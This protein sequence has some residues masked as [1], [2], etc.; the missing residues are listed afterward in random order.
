MAQNKYSRTNFTEEVIVDG[1]IEQDLADNNWDLFE[2]KR[3]MTFFTLGR[4]YIG[5]PDLLSLKLYGKMD[6]WWLLAKAND[7]D[8]FW[9]DIKVGDVI[10]V[11]DVR[12]FEDFY[13][14]VRK[15]RKG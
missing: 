14:S 12:D 1:I 3:P 11:P 9:N 13:A 8:D 15:R 2:I 4:S 10:S 7:I 5:R 6:Y